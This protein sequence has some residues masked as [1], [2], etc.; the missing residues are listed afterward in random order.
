MKQ[1][2]E[3]HYQEISFNEIHVEL[4]ISNVC[5]PVYSLSVYTRFSATFLLCSDDF[6]F[7]FQK[8]NLTS[9]QNGSCIYRK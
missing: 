8:K 3:M 5:Q 9:Q 2:M 4:S 7:Y 6:V 1:P